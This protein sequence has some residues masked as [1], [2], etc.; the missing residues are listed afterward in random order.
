MNRET[1]NEVLFFGAEALLAIAVGY[2]AELSE[3]LD[4]QHAFLFGLLAFVAIEITR[5]RIHS[6]HLKRSIEGIDVFIKGLVGEGPFAE[7]RLLYGYRAG[8]RVSEKQVRVSPEDV[9]RFW[10]DCIARAANRWFVTTYASPDD[11]WKLDWGTA[12]QNIQRERIKA[13]CEI[14]RTF[15]VDSSEERDKLMEVMKGQKKI[16]VKVR[17][18]YAQELIGVGEVNLARSALGTLDVAVV[19]DGWVYRTE[20]D[21]RRHVTGASATDD[22]ALLDRALFLVHEAYG[23]GTALA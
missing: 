20:L 17:W 7:L 1:R 13:G 8:A 10:R 2:L 21:S 3:R 14:R 22:P 6:A 12:S 15:V 19:D 18:I 5:L 9:R 16:G 11:T 23:K 4:R